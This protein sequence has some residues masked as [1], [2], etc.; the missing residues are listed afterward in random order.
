MATTQPTNIK[1]PATERALPFPTEHTHTHSQCWV[2]TTTLLWSKLSTKPPTQS[3]ARPRLWNSLATGRSWVGPWDGASPPEINYFLSVTHTPSPD[4]RDGRS[5]SRGIFHCNFMEAFLSDITARP[6]AR[7]AAVIWRS[8]LEGK[9]E[10]RTGGGNSHSCTELTPELE[11]DQ[12]RRKWKLYKS[13]RCCLRFWLSLEND[14]KIHTDKNVD[15]SGMK[16]QFQSGNSFG[17]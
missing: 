15:I 13:D 9:K 16:F 5:L 7:G 2:T 4:P 1:R 3:F 6:R 11:N 17:F 10:G 12:T 8:R 14:K